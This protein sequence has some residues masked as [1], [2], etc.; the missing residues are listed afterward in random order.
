MLPLDL[1]FLYIGSPTRM[2]PPLIPP[3]GPD[4]STN[5]SHHLLTQT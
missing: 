1:T 3:S 4:K 5:L 2:L